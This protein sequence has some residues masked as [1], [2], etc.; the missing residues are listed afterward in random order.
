LCPDR[1]SGLPLSRVG[2]RLPASVALGGGDRYSP[3]YDRCRSDARR[4]PEAPVFHTAMSS[5]RDSCGSSTYANTSA[6]TGRAGVGVR[7]ANA[8][9]DIKGFLTCGVGKG[10]VSGH[11]RPQRPVMPPARIRPHS[12]TAGRPRRRPSDRGWRRSRRSL[13]AVR[14]PRRR[15]SQPTST[16]VGQ[17]ATRPTRPGA[18]ISSILRRPSW[19]WCRRPVRPTGLWNARAAQVGQWVSWPRT[20]PAGNSAVCKLT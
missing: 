2:H 15:P 4:G 13:A 12:A 18:L 7:V 9:T 17:S 20:A 1:G 19:K 5:R 6:D 11:T 8:F 3:N 16:S 10:N 14:L